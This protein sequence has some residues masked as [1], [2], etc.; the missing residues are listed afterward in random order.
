MA[1]K[2]EIMDQVRGEFE[3]WEELLEGLQDQ[4]ITDRLLPADLSI[5]DVVAHL[6]AWQQLSLARLE[7]GLEH[8]TPQFPAW[9]PDLDP[10]SDEDLDQ[11]NAWIHEKYLDEP[12]SIVYQQWRDGFRRFMELGEAIPEA[13]LMTPGRYA[14]ME[15]EPLSLVLTA[16]YEHHHVEHLLPL[17]EWLQERDIRSPGTE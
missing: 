15:G 7:A 12:W 10:E 14:W 6:M 9:P 16:S 2:R 4:Q 3:R 17:M 11:V 8:R 13:D 1:D 5:K